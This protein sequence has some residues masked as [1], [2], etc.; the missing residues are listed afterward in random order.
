ME[1]EELNHWLC[2]IEVIL[3]ILFIKICAVNFIAC[4]NF[5]VDIFA[6]L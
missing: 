4:L 5:I 6:L 3:I 2:S 1:P